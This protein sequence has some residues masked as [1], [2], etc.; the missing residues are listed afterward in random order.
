MAGNLAVHLI[1]ELWCACMCLSVCARVCVRVYTGEFGTF[2]AATTLVMALDIDSYIEGES[3]YDDATQTFFLT[4]EAQPPGALT[5][6]AIATQHS[7]R[8]S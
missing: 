3:E 2:W 6:L 5:A 1:L 7:S 4:R 8:T